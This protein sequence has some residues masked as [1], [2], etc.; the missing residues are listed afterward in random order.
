[1]NVFLTILIAQLFCFFGGGYLLPYGF[2]FFGLNII[3]CAI[4]YNQSFFLT[5]FQRKN[6]FLY[7]FVT[8]YFFTSDFDANS[9][10]FVFSAYTP[11]LFSQFHKKLLQSNPVGDKPTKVFLLIV[12][13][14]IWAR[15]TPIMVFA[16]KAKLLLFSR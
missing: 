6:I 11:I 10:L 1:M 8:F 16:L 5:I 9:T 3:Y 13:V 15:E 2:L 7:L 14:A 12:F 4:A